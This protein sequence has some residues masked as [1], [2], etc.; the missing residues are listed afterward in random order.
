MGKS[1]NKK[2]Q[3]RETQEGDLTGSPIEIKYARLRTFAMKTYLHLFLI[4]VIGIIAYSNTFHLPFVFDDIYQI[5]GNQMIRDLDNF[6]LGLKGHDFSPDDRYNNPRRIVGY[7][8]FALN[9][10]FGGFNVKGYHLTNLF[11][12]I[13]NAMLVYFFVQLTFKTP[14]FNKAGIGDEGLGIV[15]GKQNPGTGDPEAVYGPQSP[16][17]DPQPLTPAF[18]ALFSAL[19]FVSHPL[20]TQAVTYIVQRFASLATLFYLLSLVLYINGRLASRQAGKLASYLLALVSAVLAMKTK[21]IAFTLPLVIILYESTFFAAPL[22]KKLLFLL[23][24]ALTLLI[25]P[26]SVIHSDRPFGELLSDLGENTRVQT[27]MPRWDY[28]M[29]EMRV[30]V[31]YIRLIFLPVNQ[32][33]DYDYPI[34]HSLLTPPVFMSFLLLSA[35]LAVA[36]YLLY[37]SRQA[38]KPASLQADFTFELSRLVAFG[39]FWFFITLSVESSIIPI[40]DV[41]YEHRVYLPS[42]GLFTAIATG[43]FIVAARLKKEKSIVPIFV[44]ITLALSAATYARNNIW[45]D[46]AIL[47]EDVAK[48]SPNKAR[49]HNNLGE[50]YYRQGRLGEAMREFQTALV[51]NPSYAKAHNNMGSG[52][53]AQGFLERAIEEFQI[54][55]RL[56][57]DYTDAHYNLGQAFLLRGLPHEAIKEFKT[58]LRLKPDDIDARRNIEVLSKKM[59]SR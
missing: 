38:A 6:R 1:S 12:H 32:N 31:T 35:L 16:I 24:V 15:K 49:P 34:Y 48:K 40:V 58:T 4:A 23:P 50:V 41:I 17:P 10:R 30:I 37:K 27:A 51:L 43:I 59:E 44:L 57:P 22:K 3:N 7:L 47:W 46:D 45:K 33:L 18:I 19:L 2:K 26:I 36:V 14:Y 9:Y 29:T 5:K 21:E 52:Y 8:S 13:V 11:I 54:V 56:A 42:A 20:Q 55:V 53:A 25:V 39:I 28:L